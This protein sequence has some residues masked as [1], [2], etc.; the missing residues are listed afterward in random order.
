M[1]DVTIVTNDVTQESRGGENSHIAPSS[2]T[3]RQL[4]DETLIGNVR[5]LGSEYDDPKNGA[6]IRSS[7]GRVISGERVRMIS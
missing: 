3:W 4:T 2:Q 1:E 5:V 7:R 6:Q